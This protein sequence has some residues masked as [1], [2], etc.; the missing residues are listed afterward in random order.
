L[1]TARG[2]GQDK[3]RALIR[4]VDDNKK[5]AQRAI[6]AAIKE[7]ANKAQSRMDSNLNSGEAD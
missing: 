7:A 2:L 5:N 4:A 1:P 6:F 3:G